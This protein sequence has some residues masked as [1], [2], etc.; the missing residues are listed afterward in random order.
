[1]AGVQEMSGT[2]EA[3]RA[4]VPVQPGAPFDVALKG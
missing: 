1:M 2:R 3:A 4:A